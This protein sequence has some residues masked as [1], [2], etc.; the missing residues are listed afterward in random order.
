MEPHKNRGTRDD[1]FK[2]GQFRGVNLDTQSEIC[3]LRG[4]GWVAS[5]RCI[6]AVVVC[7]FCWKKKRREKINFASMGFSFMWNL[8]EGNFAP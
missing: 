6:L 2:Q 4:G 7:G 5:W 1:G 8:A 3:Q